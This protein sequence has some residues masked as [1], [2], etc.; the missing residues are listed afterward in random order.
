M[1]I[2]F[3]VVICTYNGAT[4]LPNVLDQLQS[5]IDTEAIPWEILVVDNNSTDSTKQ[6]VQQYQNTCFKSGQLR[7]SF[8]PEQGLA[9]AR[10][11]AVTAAKG[12]LIGFLDDDNIP[13]PTWVASAY[14]FAQNHPHAGAYGSR[15]QGEFEVPPPDD[16][17]RIAALLALTERGSKKL[18]YVPKKKVLPPGAGLVVRKQAWLENVPKRCFLQGR[19]CE[20]YLPGEDLEAL[21]HIQQAGWDIWYNPE[22]QITHQI[23]HWRLKKDYL[24]DLCRGIGLSRYHTRMLSVKP[25]QAPVLFWLYIFN[26]LRKLF[27]HLYKYRGRV[28][29]DL[30][31]ACELE[32][33]IGSLLSPAYIWQARIKKYF[34]KQRPVSFSSSVRCTDYTQN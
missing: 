6:V 7:Y 10:Q 28:K 31:A 4:R 17:Q 19:V 21:L 27:L 3:T 2:K 26:D 20:P 14:L 30:I 16:F 24:V 15:I 25:W 12:E 1:I 9:I 5:Q 18:L 23:P 13:T 32:L 11:H 29:S 33:F 34:P 8:E 22:M